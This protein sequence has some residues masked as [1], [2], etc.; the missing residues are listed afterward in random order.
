[1]KDAI[2]LY[3]YSRLTRL[4]ETVCYVPFKIRKSLII[5]GVIECTDTIF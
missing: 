1:M 4:G 3:R 5:N 2:L